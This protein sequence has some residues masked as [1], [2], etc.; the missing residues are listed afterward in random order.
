[1][2]FP[3]FTNTSTAP[4]GEKDQNDSLSSS[5]QCPVSS[6]KPRT[7]DTA[8]STNPGND[9]QA[10]RCPVAHSPDAINPHNNMPVIDQ[11]PLPS[12]KS[13]LPTSRDTSSIPRSATS[14][15]PGIKENEKEYGVNNAASNWEYPS[16]Q[17]FYNALVRK[18]W[19]FPEQHAESMVVLHNRL[20]EYAWDRVLKWE[21]RFHGGRDEAAKLELSEFAGIHDRLSRKAKLYQLIRRYF[22]KYF[23]LGPPFDRHDWVVRRPATGKKVRYV[24]DYYSARSDPISE[25]TFYLDVRPASD[26][27]D[28]V[29]M[30][31]Q[32]GIVDNAA[33]SKA[34]T[35]VVFAI[36]GAYLFWPSAMLLY[37]HVSTMAIQAANGLQSVV[38]H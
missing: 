25:P 33:T 38:M 23:T 14:Y 26:S 15:Y 37:S 35:L 9:R 28:N 2:R 11:K 1:M 13:Q 22:P 17:Q 8:Q 20:N 18:G 10:P 24:I 6:A 7:S 19:D 36:V 5:P 27:L 12:Q 4:T 3:F 16:P 34:I 29:R 31:I 30:R 32:R 21:T